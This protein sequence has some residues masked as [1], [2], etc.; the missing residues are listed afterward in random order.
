[1]DADQVPKEED[2][3]WVT[4]KSF[5]FEAQAAVL[6]ARLEAVQIPVYISNSLIASTIPMAG[7]QVNL[8]VP[9]S[10]LSHAQAILHD[11]N[12]DLI[13]NEE[14]DFTDATQDDIAYQKALNERKNTPTQWMIALIILIIIV[15][16]LYAAGFNLPVSPNILDPF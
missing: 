14:T 13:Q 5:R 15:L 3:K 12:Q 6:A 9:M 1:M 10:A 7:D 8:Q 4:L 11:F 16:L 2:Q